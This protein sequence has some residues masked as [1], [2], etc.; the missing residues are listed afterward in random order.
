MG[1]LF[2]D[3]DLTLDKHIVREAAK[4]ISG[5]AQATFFVWSNLA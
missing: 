5:A 2:L 1:V 4:R 3:R